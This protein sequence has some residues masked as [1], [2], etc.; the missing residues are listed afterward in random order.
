VTYYHIQHGTTIIPTFDQ[1]SL[2]AHLDKIF[3][4]Q[5]N[6]KFT[7]SNEGPYPFGYDTSGDQ[8]LAFNQGPPQCVLR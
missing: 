4:R 1:T 6:V 8:K 3:P 2:Q 5:A 7:V